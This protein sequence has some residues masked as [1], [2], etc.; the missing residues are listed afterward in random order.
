MTPEEAA[1]V[2]RRA[3]EIQAAHLGRQD[4]LDTAAVVQ[5]GSELGLRED[6]VRSALLEQ[7]RPRTTAA[8]SPVL[9]G[10]DAELLVQRHV[11]ASPDAV[12]AHL[13]RYLELQ[14]MQRQRSRPG[15]TSWRPRRGLAAD[16]RRGL[17]LNRSIA[18][19]GVGAVEVQ[20]EP[21]DGGT[22]VDVAVSVSDARSEALG[23]LVALP[24][25]LVAGVGAV[26]GALT[27]APEAL[28][29]VPLTGVVGGAGWLGARA[30][31]SSRR[32]QVA[33]AFEGVL[34]GLP[35]R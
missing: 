13:G 17:D 12:Q 4:A 22:R 18:L 32:R 1:A 34:D 9:L 7:R 23:F 2:L 16:L 5:L 11:A 21:E 33:E 24:V 8:A 25:G 14:W 6:A 31:V 26:V 20:T 30:V 29:S 15:A 10:L 3:A 19:K 35:A 27:T 28:L